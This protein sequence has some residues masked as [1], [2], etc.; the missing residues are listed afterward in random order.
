[1][2]KFLENAVCAVNQDDPQD[3]KAYW[4]NLCDCK[5]VL[6]DDPVTGR[7]FIVFGH[8][9]PHSD[10]YLGVQFALCPECMGD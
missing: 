1:M 6:S 3:V 4:C 10:D 8:A 7:F 2:H 9:V 5:I